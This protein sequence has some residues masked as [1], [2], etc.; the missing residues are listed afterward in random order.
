[1]GGGRV[2]G[3][4]VGETGRSALMSEEAVTKASAAILL[5][6]SEIPLTIKGT[7]LPNSS[8]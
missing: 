1:M 4:E 2:E 5:N 7:N 6:R 3:V 8:E